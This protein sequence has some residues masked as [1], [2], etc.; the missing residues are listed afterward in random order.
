MM[1]IFKSWAIF[2][3]NNMEKEE[4]KESLTDKLSKEIVNTS[5]DRNIDYAELT[6]DE[7][8]TNDP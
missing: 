6:I 8:L 1:H 3:N 4:S 7:I 5:I 2:I